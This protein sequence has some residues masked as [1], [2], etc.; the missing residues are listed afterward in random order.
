MTF[1]K[2]SPLAAVFALASCSQI[3]SPLNQPIS[4]DYSPLDGPSVSYENRQVRQTGPGYQA[5]QWVETV[6]PNGTFFDRIPRGSA[7]ADQV[8]SR[9]TPMKVIG[10]EDS[11][12]KVELEDG[13]VGFVPAIMVAEPSNEDDSSPLL[14]PPPSAPLERT[15]PTLS[16]DE[17]TFTPDAPN[18]PGSSSIPPPSSFDDPSAPLPLEDEPERGPNEVLIP[19]S[20]GPDPS[21]TEPEL[22]EDIGSGTIP[23]PTN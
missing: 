18:A 7:A 16:E 3:T 5:G 17:S 23:P 14:P 1:W 22:E 15:S 2:F 21:L 4:S 20:A 6:M 19:T 9:G 8:L 11:Y 10:T 12:V 13:S